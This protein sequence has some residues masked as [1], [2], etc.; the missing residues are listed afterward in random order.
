M[1]E[2]AGHK[3]GQFIGEYCE[4]ALEPLLQEFADKHGLFLDK[5]GPRPARSGKRLR[6]M[7]RYG[8]GHDLDYVLERGGT[9]TMV[10]TPV[11]FIESAWRRYTKHSR[12]KAQEIQGAV[13]PI[14]EK[15]H[16]SAPMLGCILA[17]VYTAGA[18]EQLRSIGFK[19]LYFTY[20]SVVSAF[21]SVGIDVRFSESTPD[22][23]FDRKMKRWAKVPPGR[24]LE[25]WKR[26]LELNARNVEEFMTHLERTVKRQIT[27]VRIIPLHGS[28]QDC[29]SVADAIH[30]VV[31]YNET[32]PS[33]PLVRYEVLIRY[34]N[35]NKI[36][37]QF[38]DKATT[39]E[40]LQAYQTGNWTPAIEVHDEDVE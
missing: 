7:D 10:G 8:N 32:A 36:E 23:E 16:F 17:G 22:A 38:D 35:G 29:V 19:V 37:A 11:A 13:L 14:A 20:E 1:A 18:L 26:L 6:W 9:P 15:H 28:A 30:F 31:G 5:K 2:A 27:A 40:F 12:N 34:D 24:R 3:F 4:S 25:V 33:G 39:I 21:S